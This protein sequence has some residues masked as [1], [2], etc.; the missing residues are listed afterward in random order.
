MLINIRG[1]ML[2]VMRETYWRQL[3]FQSPRYTGRAALR[4]VKPVLSI[5]TP[6][7]GPITGM[8][9][10]KPAMV[11]RKSPKRITIPYNSIMKPTSAQ[12][13]SISAR[14]TKKAAVPLSFCLRAKKRTV[15]CGPIIIV[16]PIKKRI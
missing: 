9:R 15:F 12:R 2:R 11:P 16:R 7:Y 1:Q 13:M 10:A 5:T 4:R 3:G 14:P 8:L 6:R